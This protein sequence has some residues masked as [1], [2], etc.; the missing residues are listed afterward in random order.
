MTATIS[1]GFNIRL[2]DTYNPILIMN[3]LANQTISGIVGSEIADGSI[4]T[5]Q[6]ATGAITAAKIEAD[7]VNASHI[8]SNTI[9]ADEIN[10]DAV[11]TTKILAGN[12]TTEKLAAG[13]VTSTKMTVSE[14]SAIS[15]AM[16]EITSGIITAGTLRT[17]ASGTRV[18]IDSDG[19][20]G[21]DATLGQT[22]KLLTDGS[23]PVF[24][25]GTIQSATIIDTTIISNDFKSSS[26]LPWVEL[27]DSGLAY[28]EAAS[29]ALYGDGTQYGDGTN[30]GTG[31]TFFLGNSAKPV[32][33]VEAE[34]TLS[35]IRMYNR[36]SHSTG[37]S[38]IGDLEV[39]SGK[40]Y[41]CTTAGTPGTFTECG[42]G[43]VD[44]TAD[45]TGILPFGNGG[46]GLSSW[47]QYLIPYAATTTSIGQIA[48]GT[49]G[50]VLTSGGAGVA[51]GFETLSAATKA[52]D[53]LA[54][55]AINTTLGNV[56]LD[57]INGNT[58]YVGATST[59]TTIDAALNAAA[60]GDTILVSE[61]TYTET[62]TFDD[63]NVTVKAIGSKENT[64]I[65]QTNVN[66]VDFSTKEGCVLE[67]FTIDMSASNGTTDYTL[68]GAND[69]ANGTPNIIRDCIIDEGGG[70]TG[71]ACAVY[72]T[73]GDWNFYNCTFIRNSSAGVNQQAWGVRLNGAD[74]VKFVHCKW[75]VDFAG[76][77][78]GLTSCMVITSAVA[79]VVDIWDSE[80]YMD[81]NQTTTGYPSCFYIDNTGGFTLNIYNTF[82]H[83]YT[84][85][86]GLSKCIDCQGS[87]GTINS[88]NNQ[89]YSNNS[90]G[91]Q[92]WAEITANT[93]LNSYGDTILDGTLSNAGT[94][95]SY[96]AESGIVTT[97]VDETKFSHK[98][99]VIIGGSTYYIMLTDS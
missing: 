65:T 39:V 20:L 38:V 5:T 24:A 69:T 84:S 16:G 86:T 2:G 36:S 52:L 53:N 85:T 95:N 51:P 10:T 61:G 92:L 74:N 57:K 23:A 94:F 14:L 68:T 42:K 82:M 9:S 64:T 32:I 97:E 83:A 63:D 98:M 7:A 89:Y 47:T 18:N 26:E 13:A 45:V 66:V 17:A 62:I 76:A 31:V 40:L 73:D 67:G 44:L 3:V 25:S 21:Y 70:A 30:Y 19:I 43:T 56:L 28:R 87:T 6:I 34:R 4:D 55:V 59:Y 1:P 58:L 90:D 15:A 54:S 46:T 78:I 72:L 80:M 12:I 71:G 75:D 96:L 79:T 93:T 50:Q 35:D 11:T 49:D 29:G 60:A 81:G 48:I 88:Y 91:D 77:G 33:S 99:Q 37:A 22:F 41:I 27:G 8:A